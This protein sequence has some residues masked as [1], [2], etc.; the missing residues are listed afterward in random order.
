MAIE[1]T[2]ALIREH[3]M[4]AE[5][6]FNRVIGRILESFDTHRRPV[7]EGTPRRHPGRAPAAAAQPDRP[8][9]RE[10]RRA[11][12]RIGDRG[13][14]SVA[15]GHR[16]DRPPLR[17]R[18]GHR[19]SAVARRTPPSWRA[20]TASR[21]W[22]ALD[23]AARRR[24]ITATRSSSTATGGSWCC[25]RPPE[26]LRG[27]RSGAAAFRRARAA[28]ADPE[29]VPGH[30][31]RRPHDRVVRQHQV[32]R[33]CGAGASPR[34]P[35]AS[36]CTAPST[37][38]CRAAICRPRTNRWRPTVGCCGLAGA[39]DRHLPHPR[40]RR[41]QVRQLLGTGHERAEPVPRL[42]RHPLPAHPARHLPHPVA[43][44]SCAP[45]P[46]ASSRSCFR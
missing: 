35:R 6:A 27:V 38:S 2:E 19:R 14:R 3:L 5:F 42:A 11:E 23:G 26:T 13:A 46:R 17:A 34:A 40:H 39:R 4:C 30:H 21:R 9:S 12:R 10:L 43:R 15:V 32:A 44:V 45:R 22:S 28:A 33:R 1:D 37:S 8:G 31:A 7:P 36:V 41:R 18:G 16:D 24:R 25:V 20:A 29:G